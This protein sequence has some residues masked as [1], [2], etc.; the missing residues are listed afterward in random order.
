MSDGG[1]RTEPRW[2]LLIH[3]IPPKPDYLRVKIGRRLLRVGAVPVKNSIYVLPDAG[4]SFED[5][6]WIRTEIID[7]GGDASICR[8]E[9]IDGLTNEQIRHLFRSARD[10][11]YADI[12]AAAHALWAAARHSGPEGRQARATRP[13]DDLA[14]LRKR[15]ATVAAIDFFE[16]PERTMAKEALAI[17]EAELEPHRATP[18]PASPRRVDRAE[19]RG[20]TWVTRDNVFVDRMASAWLIRRFIDPDAR[21]KFV[22]EGKY[23]LTGRELRFDMF[24]GEFTHEGDRCTFEVL[25]ERLGPDDSALRSLA[26]VVH[27]IDL[28][29]GKFGRDDAPGIERVLAGIASAY[30]DDAT[31]LERAGQLFDELQALFAA[32]SSA[33]AR[34]APSMSAGSV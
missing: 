11:E 18:G 30:P 28:K 34:V 21:F 16:A 17:L 4:Q 24:E 7:G 32:E 31:R 2:L 9:F 26:Q 6:Q 23:R 12:S 33:M 8:A 5:F 22:H 25:L 19:Y 20:R 13:N 15:F 10:A 29:D 3:Q 1:Q 27:D 14:R